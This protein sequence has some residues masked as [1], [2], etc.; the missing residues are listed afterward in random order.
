MLFSSPS[1]RTLLTCSF[2]TLVGSVAACASTGRAT[3]EDDD[4]AVDAAPPIP[5][6]DASAPIFTDANVDARTPTGP[7]AVFGHSGKTLYKL[8]PDTKAV[9]VIGDF[10]GCNEGKEQVIDIALDEKSVMY[11]TTYSGLYRI[12][13]ATAKCTKVADAPA[14]KSFP[15]SLS[16][17]P[18]GSLDPATE[19]LVGYVGADYVRI[20]PQTGALTTI[21]KLEPTGKLISSG[22]IVSVIEGP[23]YLTVKAT[24]NTG[25]C[26]ASDCLVEVDPKTGALTKNWG[27]LKGQ[28]DVFGV[29]F[30]GG[31]IYGFTKTGVLFEVVPKG[32]SITLNELTIPS[33]PTDLSFFGAGST[34]SAPVQPK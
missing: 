11:G 13:T 30:W 28:A 23:T 33:K 27:E 19:A 5:T 18:K 1:L 22:D 24:G 17:V 9:S 15:N 31:S 7:A 2:V 29:A 16:F 10:S 14:T 6:T 34:T 32:S 8:D 4:A 12:E 3:F 21:G 26:S 20:D 25:Q